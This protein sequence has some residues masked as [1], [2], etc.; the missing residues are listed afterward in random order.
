MNPVSE[1]PSLKVLEPVT[2]EFFTQDPRVVAKGILGS[3]LVS[4]ARG[5]EAGGRIVEAEAYLGGSDPGS[6]AAT[7]EITKRNVVMYGPPGSVYVYFAYGNHHMLNFVCCPQ[8]EAGAVLVRAIEPLIGV[9]VMRSRRG[10]RP[11]HELAS[12]PGKVCAALGVD[13]S[14]NAT[15]LGQGRIVVYHWQHPRASDVGVSGRIGL[16]AGHDLDL[17]YYVRGDRFVSRGRAGVSTKRDSA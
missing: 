2:A 3:L 13:L 9:E 7:K 1:P 16:S 17:R 4:S 11:L 5:T 10:G 14:D 8:G 6:H 12:G 15:M